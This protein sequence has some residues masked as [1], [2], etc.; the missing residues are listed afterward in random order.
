MIMKNEKKKEKIDDRTL[1]AF[2]VCN[3]NTD[4]SFAVFSHREIE[5]SMKNEKKC[6]NIIIRHSTY[7][8]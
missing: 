4:D 1:Q 2:L 5:M 7:N 8:G 6:A 3:D